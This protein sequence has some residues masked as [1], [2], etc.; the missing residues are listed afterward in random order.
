MTASFWVFV[1]LAV[2]MLVL[3]LAARSPLW[4]ASG[5]TGLISLLVVFALWHYT[6][7]GSVRTEAWL[8][9]TSLPLVALGT[10][11]WSRPLGKLALAL[12]VV[13]TAALLVTWRWAVSQP[14]GDNSAT[15]VYATLVLVAMMA[16]F[17]I[18]G[19]IGMRVL[20]ER[21]RAAQARLTGG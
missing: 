11:F 15:I 2:Q 4:R 21:D 9:L 14:P 10:F 13:L 6:Q 7:G 20:I 19:V 17:M 1:A 8:V 12:G 3:A 5:V 18:A 16:L